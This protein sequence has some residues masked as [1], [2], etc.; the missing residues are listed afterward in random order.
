M[1]KLLPLL[2]FCCSCSTV[3]VTRTPNGT[4]HAGMTSLL[5]KQIAEG[6]TITTREGD[7]IS[8][9]GYNTQNPDPETVKILGNTQ[10]GLKGI[11]K[12]SDM[13]T[14]G[15]NAVTKAVTSP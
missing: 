4:L 1:T 7:S 5:G 2:L 6:A 15:T 10:L 12:G 3:S 13:L 8:V 14:N 9:T 11:D